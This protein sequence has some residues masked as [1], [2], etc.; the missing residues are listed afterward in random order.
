MGLFKFVVMLITFFK[1]VGHSASQ[2]TMRK[3]NLKKSKKQKHEKKKRLFIIKYAFL[4][5][6]MHGS[7]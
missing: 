3:K 1:E 4:F 7:I 6:L 5:L 2:R